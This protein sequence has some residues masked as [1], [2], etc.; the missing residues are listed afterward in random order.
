MSVIFLGFN[1][2]SIA[3]QERATLADI[4]NEMEI[5]IYAGGYTQKDILDNL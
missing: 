5:D 1:Y 2:D 4:Y 3:I